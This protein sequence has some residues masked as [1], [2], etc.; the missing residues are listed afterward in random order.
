MNTI[1]PL[2]ALL[3]TLSAIDFG[4]SSNSGMK[5]EQP[6]TALEEALGRCYY[7]FHFLA[8][9]HG[10]GDDKTSFNHNLKLAL[11]LR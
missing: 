7:F 3:S 9:G 1:T 2:G 6:N 11:A 10:E 5:E 4:S 8:Y